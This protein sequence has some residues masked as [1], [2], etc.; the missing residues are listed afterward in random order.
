MH[1]GSRTGM[2]ILLHALQSLA[3]KRRYRTTG[4]ADVLQN[5]HPFGGEVEPNHHLPE[6]GVRQAEDAIE[7]VSHGNDVEDG[8]LAGNPLS[9]DMAVEFLVDE[10]C[11]APGDEV[12]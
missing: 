10:R 2:S 11:Q 12:Q 7:D 6:H 4:S 3:D 9:P 8:D 1:R 5:R